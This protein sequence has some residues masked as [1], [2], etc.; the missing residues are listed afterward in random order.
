MHYGILTI[1]CTCKY[2]LGSYTDQGRFAIGPRY[3]YS[4]HMQNC[5]EEGPRVVGSC[6][7][8]V[9]NIYHRYHQTPTEEIKRLFCV[10]WSLRIPNSFGESLSRWNFVLPK[11]RCLTLYRNMKFKPSISCVQILSCVAFMPC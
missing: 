2:I 10:H 11:R 4:W 7:T 1:E 9:Y 8:H 6:L 3:Y 5:I